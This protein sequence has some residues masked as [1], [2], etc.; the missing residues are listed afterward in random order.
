MKIKQVT[1][2]DKRNMSHAKWAAARN[3][4]LGGSDIASLMGLNPFESAIECF[5]RKCLIIPSSKPMQLSSYSGIVMEDVIYK[6][7]WKY[8]QPDNPTHE[9]LIDNAVN[10]RV[11]R[12]AK[13]KNFTVVS[14][15]FPWLA[16]NVDYVID[17]NDYTPPGILDCKNSLNYVV[18]A[19]ESG[20][21][22][23]Y[24]IQVNQ[25]MFVL[26]YEYSELAYLLD[27][28]YPEIIPIL[29]DEGIQ[30]HIVSYSKDFWD[31]VVEGRKVWM[32]VSMSEAERL[33]IISQIE[34]EVDSSKSLENY[35]KDRFKDSGKKGQLQ[36]TPEILATAKSYLKCNEEMNSVEDAKRLEGNL[37]R[38]LLLTN[39]VD[40]IL[41]NNKALITYR[42]LEG[43]SPSLRVSKELMKL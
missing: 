1:L 25:Y 34:P 18:N 2:I 30:K 29:P 24:V 35:L 10:K 8:Y 4:Y 31:K 3:N 38:H 26:G 9:R 39:G 11:I 14:K 37:I 23:G 15:E 21:N 22:P 28:R 36:G 41:F 27:G 42:S 5:H 19:Y 16:S 13:K 6:N 32:D 12:T 33:Q 40:E 7:Y 17:K 43:K 20:V